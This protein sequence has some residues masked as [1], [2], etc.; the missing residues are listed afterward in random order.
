[1][2]DSFEYDVF[3]SHSNSSDI[4]VTHR[5]VSFQR[6]DWTHAFAMQAMG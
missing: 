6:L 4:I 2:S 1:M 5:R 3:L